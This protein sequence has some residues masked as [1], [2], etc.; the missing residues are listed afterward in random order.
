MLTYMVKM[1]SLWPSRLCELKP[2]SLK[3]RATTIELSSVGLWSR[4]LLWSTAGLI[5][6]PRM[7]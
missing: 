5:L 6:A 4:S 2:D 7:I 1:C 3:S